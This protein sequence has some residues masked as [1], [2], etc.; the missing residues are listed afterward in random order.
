MESDLQTQIQGRCA[1]W[2]LFACVRVLTRVSLS[3]APSL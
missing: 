3:P 1:L 2:G